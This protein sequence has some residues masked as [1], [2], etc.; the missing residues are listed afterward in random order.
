MLFYLFKILFIVVGFPKQET[1]YSNLKPPKLSKPSLLIERV[2][3]QFQYCKPWQYTNILDML[4]ICFREKKKKNSYQEQIGNRTSIFSE[5][6]ENNLQVGYQSP[7][8]S[9]Q[10]G[11][12]K[13][14]F[15]RRQTHKLMKIAERLFHEL[16]CSILIQD[17]KKYYRERN[18]ETTEIGKLYS[19]QLIRNKAPQQKMHGKPQK[20]RVKVLPLK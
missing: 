18:P 8:S 3:N 5:Y 20:N 9:I 12:T 11:E 17:V 6:A 7:V 15:L 4:K 13:G 16:K 14:S 2:R 1:R 10:N 19:C